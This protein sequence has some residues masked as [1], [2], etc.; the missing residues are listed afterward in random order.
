MAAARHVLDMPMTEDVIRLAESA[1]EAGG[2]DSRIVELA[3]ASASDLEGLTLPLEGYLIQHG[4]LPMTQLDALRTLAIHIS[5]G[6][7]DG[8]VT[9]SDGATEIWRTS[10][11]LDD[12][13]THEF[14][15][16]IYAAS[17]IQERPREAARFEQDIIEEARHLLAR[18]LPKAP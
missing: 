7:M 2:D 17:E 10:L 3:G 11:L 16:F 13:V 15:G 12:L 1:L 8:S 4:H 18:V 6:I 5:R 14:D 9:P